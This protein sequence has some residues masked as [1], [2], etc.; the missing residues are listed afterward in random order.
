MSTRVEHDYIVD[1]EASRIL[2]RPTE[3]SEKKGILIR[4]PTVNNILQSRP[5]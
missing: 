5:Q 4:R 1:V 3:I 2:G